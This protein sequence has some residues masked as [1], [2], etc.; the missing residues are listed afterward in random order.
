MN[1][2][3]SMDMINYHG[4]TIANVPFNR[5]SIVTIEAFLSSINRSRL[6]TERD[7]RI[8]GD[9]LI[10]SLRRF[11]IM[12]EDPLETFL[13]F[14]EE[15]SLIR[16][17]PSQEFMVT[18]LM[19]I[20]SSFLAMGSIFKGDDIAD[21]LAGLYPQMASVSASDKATV[22]V[23]EM[24]ANYKNSQSYLEMVT[25]ES[26]VKT[27]KAVPWIVPFLI[28]NHCDSRLMDLLLSSINA[29]IQAKKD[30]SKAGEEGANGNP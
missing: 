27:L 20:N 7:I 8:Q 19:E 25:K 14:W 15:T 2:V 1:N 23:R 28:M 22:D 21:L 11:T 16:T 18:F 9:W 12:S 24:I 3:V 17:G 10:G 4:I 6:L 13:K 5:L 29:A 26:L 30:S